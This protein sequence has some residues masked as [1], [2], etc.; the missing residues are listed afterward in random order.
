MEMSLVAFD[1]AAKMVFRA[2][3]ALVFS[4]AVVHGMR[5]VAAA[6]AVFARGVVAAVPVSAG[7]SYE[8]SVEDIAAFQGERAEDTF[9]FAVNR[10]DAVSTDTASVSALL[11]YTNS[12]YAEMVHFDF[13]CGAFWTAPYE[14]ANVAVI[15]EALAWKLFGSFNVA[16][17]EIVVESRCYTVQ[18]VARQTGGRYEAWLP[19]ASAEGMGGAPVLYMKPSAYHAVDSHFA[20]R[21]ALAAMGKHAGLYDIID[22][23]TY[24]G[25]MRYRTQMALLL[26][27]LCGI[28]LIVRVV[29]GSVLRLRKAGA[30]K[31]FMYGALPGLAVVTCLALWQLVR[32]PFHAVLFDGALTE[33]LFNVQA[34]S[35]S[36]AGQRPLAQLAAANASANM[37]FITAC[38]AVGV[39]LAAEVLFAVRGR[40]AAQNALCENETL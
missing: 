20:V 29:I 35:E 19:Y 36:T 26:C 10:M 28:G 23:T 22:T 5:A 9:S 39:W 3:A 17:N 1:K 15:S 27:G 13:L 8:F 7:S 18:G 21:D 2:C 38:A 34:I 33:V 37:A 14:A 31:V 30:W 6:G 40:V 16:G 11:T 4:V 25:N 32:F 24:A 12:P